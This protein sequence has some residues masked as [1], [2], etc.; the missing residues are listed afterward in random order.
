MNNN[1]FAFIFILKL[2]LPR[3]YLFDWQW[4][5]PNL[6]HLLKENVIYIWS[7]GFHTYDHVPVQRFL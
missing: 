1:N 2:G 7:I 6:A 4:G 3:K 5:N